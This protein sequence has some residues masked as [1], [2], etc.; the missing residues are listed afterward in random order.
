MRAIECPFAKLERRRGDAGGARED[1]PPDDRDRPDRHDH[2]PRH[3]ISEPRATGT[4]RK[5]VEVT[6]G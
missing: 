2:H 4:L 1:D 3:E 6:M 5:A